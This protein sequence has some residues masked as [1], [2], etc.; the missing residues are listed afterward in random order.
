MGKKFTLMFLS[1]KNGKHFSWNINL[2]TPV[3]VVLFIIGFCASS[4][5]LITRSVSMYN[6]NTAYSNLVKELQ[7]EHLTFYYSPEDF[8]R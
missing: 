8:V 1:E 3:I 5:F 2:V 6:E 7:L 4:G